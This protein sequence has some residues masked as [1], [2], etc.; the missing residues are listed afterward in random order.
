LLGPVQLWTSAG[1]VDLGPTKQ[2]A[3]LAALAV[4][5]GQPVSTETLIDRVWDADPPAGVRS[6]LYTYVSRLRRALRGSATIGS[7][8]Q[9]YVLDVDR[10]R[11]DMYRFRRLV[12]EARRTADDAERAVLLRR[13]LDLWRAEPLAD[14]AGD[15]A[16]RVRA[17]WRSLHLDAVGAWARAELQRANP[18]AVISPLTELTVEYPF[19]ESL[20]G[21]LMRALHE[22][23][24]SAEA[25]DL[26][27][28]LRRRL[29]EQLGTDPGLELQDL[30]RAVL[31][32]KSDR[33]R[34]ASAPA[35][36][37]ATPAQLPLDAFG[38]TGRV[39]QLAQLDAMLDPADGPTTAVVISALSGTAGVGKTALAM[40][41]AHRVADQFPD[42]QLYVNLR[43]FGP[44]R[45]VMDP[46]EALRGFLDA[47][48]VPA[49]R[50]PAGLTAQSALY[51]SLLA[52]RRMLVVLDNARD[53]EQV[54]PLLPGG[55]GCLVLVTSRNPL[56][57][58]VAAEGA[59]PLVLDLLT[60]EEAVDLLARRLGRDRV[61][62]EPDAVEEIVTRCARLPLALA[63]VAA[64]AA[65]HP[66]FPLAAFAAELRDAHGGLDALTGPD[67]TTDV[68]A[69]F[70]WSYTGLSA[71][72][73]RLFRL[74]SLHPGPEIRVSAAASLAGLPVRTTRH[75]LAELD[76]LQLIKESTAGRYSCHD[77]LRA[78]AAELAEAHDP[79]DDRH[80]ATGRLLDHYLHTAHAA[81]VLFNPAHGATPPP[82]ADSGA[83]AE[84]LSDAEE[85]LAWFVGEHH[86]LIVM[87]E[88][89]H[90]AGFDAHAWHLA[91]AIS[92]YLQRQGHWRDE[93]DSE[94]TALAA[95]RRLGNLAAAAQINRRMARVLARLGQYDEAH[96]HYEQAL[97]LFGRLGDHTGQGNVHLGLAH[98]LELQGR[99]RS[100]LH[101]ARQSLDL[102]RLARND[103]GQAKALNGIGWL[104]TLLGEHRQTLV[105]CGQ[106]LALQTKIGD[107]YGLTGTWDSLGHAHHHLGQYDEAMHCYRQSLALRPSSGDRYGEAETLIRLGDTLRVTGQLAETREV[108]K[109]A[110]SILGEIDHPDAPNLAKRLAELDA[111]EPTP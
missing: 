20:A 75:L 82:P 49:Q 12:D 14:L 5:A 95:A 13:A 62:R 30:H 61:D 73:A 48:Q 37:P 26:Y 60:Y 66:G 36:A 69:T 8:R 40:H 41:W 1:E 58:L 35:P 55:R 50:I 56:R 111:A 17:G 84:P 97:E 47:L 9:G 88:L 93:R 87:I 105:Y 78:F 59:R 4:D 70:S 23:G 74:L 15:W 72:A 86:A 3:V 90:S 81:S 91:S 104:S 43:G 44:G 29:A 63:I 64:R 108:W 67:P 6:V 110:L 39:D 80:A 71:D 68:R 79:D 32:G 100:G 96:A 77:L 19:V 54:R 38:F 11:I 92:P 10:D 83:T 53:A 76:G 46:A 25:L 51:R 21:V 89:A 106:A 85:A 98:L 34:P 102:F 16:A 45:A 33:T 42:G 65:N 7:R 57:S 2:R 99:Y 101:H 103:D 52:G 28:N 31:R 107:R 24:R 109:R 18:D 94:Q 22:A 27:A